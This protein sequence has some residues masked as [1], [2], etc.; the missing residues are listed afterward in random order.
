MMTSRVGPKNPAPLFLEYQH[1]LKTCI[2]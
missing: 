1:H 2:I